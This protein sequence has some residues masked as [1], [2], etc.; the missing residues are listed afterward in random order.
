MRWARPGT[1]LLIGRVL[2]VLI[3]LGWLELCQKLQRH[4]G[5]STTTTSS[6]AAST[7]SASPVVHSRAACSSA[8]VVP[9]WIRH[10]HCP[11]AAL[12]DSAS[13]GGR[14]RLPQQL[15]RPMVRRSARSPQ[16][17]DR[18]GWYPASLFGDV[19]SDLGLWKS[20]FAVRHTV[21]GRW[22]RADIRKV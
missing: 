2:P 12:D 17:T 22:F 21:R 7:A 14:V 11:W 9:R 1:G 5:F 19:E 10:W 3:V 20:E 13:P 4:L 6:S 15:G 16:S 8:G 18:V